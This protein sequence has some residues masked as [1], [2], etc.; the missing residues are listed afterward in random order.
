MRMPVLEMERLWIRP[1]AMDDLHEIHRILNAAFHDDMTLEA[2][3]VWLQWTVLSDEQLAQL[4][5][6]PYGDRAVVLKLTGQ[7]IGS[8]GFVPCLAAFGQ[9]PSFESAA[10]ASHLNSTEFGL[11]WAFD[12]THQRRGYATEAAQAMIHY[13]FTQ[14]RLKR[15][16]AMTEYANTASQGV[17]RKLGMRLVRNPH[18]EP[19]WLQVVGVLENTLC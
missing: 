10:S 1:F 11:F 2:R 14:L 12:P 15:I 8:V 13:A 3:R 18:P 5:Q 9:L 17:M 4:R 16:V 6:P 19:P 7:L